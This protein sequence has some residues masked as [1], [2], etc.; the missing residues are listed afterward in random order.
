MSLPKLAVLFFALL[1]HAALA[2]Q[3]TTLQRLSATNDDTLKVQA[4]TKNA[5][6]VAE[7]A[8]E[9]ALPVLA[10][11]IKVSERLAYPYGIGQAWID[12]GKRE[13]T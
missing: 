3:D 9:K 4:L 2:A 5:M 12:I 10:E 13:V 8:P 11:V 1:L 7:E 6:M